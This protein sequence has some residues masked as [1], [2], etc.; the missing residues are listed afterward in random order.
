MKAK[1]KLLDTLITRIFDKH[2]YCRSCVLGVLGDLCSENVVPK[3]YLMPILKCGCDRMKDASA[4]VR[5]KAITLLYMV[6]KYY[7]V[8]FVES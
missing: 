7:R 1:K 2:A 8:I 4:H 5:K 3:D 6:M